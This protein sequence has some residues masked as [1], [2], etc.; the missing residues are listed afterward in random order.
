MN[1]LFNMLMG[2]PQMPQVPVNNGQDMNS[3]MSQLRSDPTGMLRN[4]GFNVPDGM[5]NDPRAT[6]MHLMQ[7]GQINSPMMQKIRP[8]LN[9]MGIR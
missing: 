3:M 4:A 6:V 5:A 8:M 1:P 7:T 2:Q 9:M